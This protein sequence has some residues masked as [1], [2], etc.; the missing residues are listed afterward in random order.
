MNKKQNKTTEQRRSVKTPVRCLHC[1]H[2]SLY[3]YD[4]NP[5][6]ADC[7]QKPQADNERFPFE[8]EVASVLRQCAEYDFDP[9]EKTVEQRTK[10]HIA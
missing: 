3:R 1:L 9:N 10:Q 4:S 2:A 5:I 7:H 8:V 6:L